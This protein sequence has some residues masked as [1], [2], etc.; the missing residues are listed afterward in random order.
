MYTVYRY[1]GYKDR[2]SLEMDLKF[3]SV[4]AMTSQVV[5]HPRAG[6]VLAHVRHCIQS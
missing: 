5:I 1:I 2:R 6:T 4:Q 3:S